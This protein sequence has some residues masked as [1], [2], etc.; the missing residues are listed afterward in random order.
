MKQDW[1]RIEPTTVSQ[2]GWMTVIGKTFILPDGRVHNFEIS[3]PEN[4][5]EVAVVA[6]TVDE[7]V[8]IASQFRPGPEKVMEQL[9]GGGFERD[10]DENME[11]AAR[12]ELREETG[13][14]AGEIEFLA[15]NFRSAYSN[16]ATHYFFA[17]NCELSPAGTDHDEFEIIETRLITI[18][19]L[20]DNARNA[21]MTDVAGVFH[22]QDR[23]VALAAAQSGT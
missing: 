20:F 13:Y 8:I 1:E 16:A 7:K 21:R 5:H 10:K 22:A 11:E 4:S 6:L 12:R 3:A 14:E 23:L 9:P 18:A 17:T 2:I 15:K 19:E